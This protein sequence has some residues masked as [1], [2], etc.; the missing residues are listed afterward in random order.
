MSTRFPLLKVTDVVF[1]EILSQLEL[2]EIFN[3]SLCSPKMRD[4]V[5]CHMK[6]SIKYPLYLDTKEFKGM[7][8]GF[9]GKDGKHIPMMSVRKSGI[10]NERQFEKV[11]MKGNKGN[12]EVRV[13]ISKYDNHYEL[14]SSDDK[15]WIFGCNLVLKH[16]TDLFRKD[17]HTL[18]CNSPYS[19]VFLKYRAPVR[20][21]YSGGEDCNAYW[22]LFSYEMER[23]AKTGGLQLR[24]SLPA[25]Y[26]FTL[27]RDYIY[28]R[29][30]RAHFA[31]YD[32]VLKLAEKS[33]EV[34][35]DES[36]LLSEGLNTIFNCWLEHRIDG[37]KFLSI[38]MRSYSEFSVFKGIEHRITDTTDG[39]K[40]KS[41]T[42]ESYRLSP[43]KHLRRDD[44]V[45][46]LFTYDP[47]TRILNFG[48]L[49]GAV[50]CKKD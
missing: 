6:K 25:G 29:M 42:R 9:I 12:E 31:R 16:I 36:G 30:E 39:V 47:T 2:N 26:D 27:T 21:T 48:D 38:R 34:I 35:L 14:L 32:D 45:I 20:M 24:H 49:T 8:F 17:I 40:F 43:G 37:L 4:I 13:E 50:L 3:L 22:N 11:N 18:Y 41:Y 44:G 46:A 23:A 15:D 19:L 10:S 33:R 5:R 28:I 1:D 7:K